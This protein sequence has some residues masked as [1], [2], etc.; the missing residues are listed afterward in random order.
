MLTQALV[1]ICHVLQ[2]GAVLIEDCTTIYFINLLEFFRPRQPS[3]LGQIRVNQDV[4]REAVGPRPEEHVVA[5][6]TE[7]DW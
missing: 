5:A 3:R 2:S 4:A 6:P 1:K 7:N